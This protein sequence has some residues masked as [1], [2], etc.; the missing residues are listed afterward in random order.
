MWAEPACPWL[1]LAPSPPLSMRFC[2]SPWQ[3]SPF[4]SHS[5]P[6]PRSPWNSAF[7]MHVGGARLGGV[8][9][10]ATLYVNSA[11]EITQ[12]S[13][14]F[15]WA[16]G[17]SKGA[18]SPSPIS[19]PV[20]KLLPAIILFQQLKPWGIIACPSHSQ[21]QCL[22]LKTVFKGNVNSLIFKVPWM[23]NIYT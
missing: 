13:C 9:K 12:L 1:P 7:S 14:L 15:F 21:I 19:S 10:Q 3:Y 22:M 23:H 11:C 18:G 17:Q 6:T 4:P 16:S 2:R 20:K 5:Q 8:C